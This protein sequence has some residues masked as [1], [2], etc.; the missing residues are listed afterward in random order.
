MRLY[1]CLSGEALT[2]YDV[3]NELYR[4]FLFL[5]FIR[6]VRLA[7]A[8]YGPSTQTLLPIVILHGVL[9][10]KLNWRSSATKLAKE[11]GRQV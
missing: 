8:V 3:S 7:Y 10:H 2:I 4:T 9:G 11:S 1:V 5:L 6:A